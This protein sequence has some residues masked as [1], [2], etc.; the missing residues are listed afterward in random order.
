[1]PT[2][3]PCSD[4]VS[5]TTAAASTR[6]LAT[7]ACAT[8]ATATMPPAGSARVRTRSGHP[9]PYPPPGPTAE[10]SRS[11]ASWP[12]LAGSRPSGDRGQL[13]QAGLRGAEP[14]DLLEKQPQ[15]G[16]SRAWL[17]QG[18]GSRCCLFVMGYEQM[19]SMKGRVGRPPWRCPMHPSPL[20]PPQTTTSARTWPVRTASA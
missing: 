6:F 4:L 15:T 7:S 3:A 14:W 9:P 16:A 2:S 12:F 20:L 19:L 11:P 18:R 13:Q 17:G 1:M 5:A 10:C 8:P